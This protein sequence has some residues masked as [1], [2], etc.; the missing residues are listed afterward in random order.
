MSDRTR[1]PEIREKVKRIILSQLKNGRKYR[2]E[3]HH[4][5]CRQLGYK[6]KPLYS[7]KGNL[8]QTCEGMT[9]STFDA[10]LNE[11]KHSKIVKWYWGNREDGHAVKFYELTE[12]T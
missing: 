6:T 4:E 9:D 8:S 3:L 10:P 7:E 2:L 11:L 5:V 12:L 1:N